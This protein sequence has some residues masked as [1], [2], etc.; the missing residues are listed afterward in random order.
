MGFDLEVHSIKFCKIF[1]KNTGAED[2]FINKA[3][4]WS[5]LQRNCPSFKWRQNNLAKEYSLISQ[6]NDRCRVSFGN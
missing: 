4:F 1:A 3:M 2:M 5:A 6:T